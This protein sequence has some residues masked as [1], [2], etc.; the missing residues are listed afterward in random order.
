MKRTRRTGSLTC[1]FKELPL[2][3]VFIDDTNAFIDISVKKVSW[4][5]SLMLLVI[6]GHDRHER[7]FLQ[8]LLGDIESHSKAPM[9]TAVR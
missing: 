6:N 1:H 2:L 4:S 7:T 5:I 8:L 3:M 9:E